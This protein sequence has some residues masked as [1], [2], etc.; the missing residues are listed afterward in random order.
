MD[1]R[2]IGMAKDTENKEKVMQE[3]ATKI[4]ANRISEL[5]ARFDRKIKP[6]TSQES[7]ARIGLSKTKQKEE[8]VASSSS[9][10]Q[11]LK[12]KPKYD[13]DEGS[14]DSGET[15]FE[16]TN[17]MA[18]HKIKLQGWGITEQTLSRINY[19]SAKGK[20]DIMNK[21]ALK[22]FQDQKFKGNEIG[23]EYL[24]LITKAGKTVQ[25]KRPIKDKG[26]LEKIYAIL[27]P[28]ATIQPTVSKAK[29]GKKK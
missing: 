29:R 6:G 23:I 5:K 13:D 11:V 20:Y 17:S 3:L 28:Q 12:P 4:K 7:P 26:D 24:N 2:N 14:T 22:I 25:A 9:S 18:D 19:S 15:T 1:T 10:S 8:A 16:D 21:I 27:N